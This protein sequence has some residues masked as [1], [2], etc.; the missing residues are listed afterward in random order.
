MQDPLVGLVTCRRLPEPDHDEAPLLAA[1]SAAGVRA[2][3]LAW[4]DPDADAACFDLCVLRSCWNYYEDV[5][6]FEGWMTATAERSQLLNP[7]GVARWNLHKRYLHEL[8]A[9]GLPII[10]TAGFRRGAE[11]DLARTM[12]ERGWDDVV[13]KPAVSAA[14]YRTRRFRAD[15]VAAGQAFL[16]AL[17]ADRD[18]LVQRTMP[19]FEERGERALVWIDGEF[20]H[21]VRKEPRF[22][23]QDEEVSAALEISAAERALGARALAGMDAEL[24][25][26]RVDVVD[27]DAGAPVVA[28]VELLEP[29]LFLV[30]HPPALERLAAAVA[31]RVR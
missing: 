24:L 26:A 2:E 10:P 5:D 27:D 30:Q 4:D 3:L 31:R 12:E 15:Q 21:A 14:S 18:A 9:V 13:V 16:D 7:L 28:E 25:Y 22:D 6:A 11:V 17:L 19:A 1:L 23:D 29:S 8:E 20:T